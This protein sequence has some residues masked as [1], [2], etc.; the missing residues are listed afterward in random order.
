MVFFNIL[1]APRS[2]YIQDDSF[3]ILQAVKSMMA[4]K[5]LV[6][7]I[8]PALLVWARTSIGISVSRAA[9]QLKVSSKQLRDWEAGK[10][11]LSIVNL[12]RSAEINKRPLAAFFLPEPPAEPPI[13]MDFRCSS[14][15]VN[16]SGK[17]RGK[18]NGSS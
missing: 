11:K 16:D 15:A 10:D 2:L 17:G 6:L 3:I 9:G 18:K 7:N 1:L 14:G 5:P 12:E 8:N 13:P 4:Q